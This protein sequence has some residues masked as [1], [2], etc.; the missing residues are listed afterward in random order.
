MVE[1]KEV[2]TEGLGA[3]FFFFTL[4]GGL[5]GTKSTASSFVNVTSDMFG[6]ALFYT[7]LLWILTPISGAH[8]N[9]L[10]TL[11]YCFEKK[12]SWMD[13]LWYMLSQA[14][15]VL[16]ATLLILLDRGYL[17]SKDKY[18][19]SS[20]PGIAGSVNRW[21]NGVVGTDTDYISGILLEFLATFIFLFF[22]SAF[23]FGNEE[24][25]ALNA[26]GT[27][28]ALSFSMSTTAKYTGAALNPFH[29]IIPLLFHLNWR[30]API[31]LIGTP[32]GGIAGY[33][34][35]KIVSAIK[36]GDLNKPLNS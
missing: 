17:V 8:I 28:T 20:V 3:F 25:K 5:A 1:T 19:Y 30:A 15:G 11:G 32:L 7:F 36:K 29:Y 34:I 13:G 27:G 26:F 6:I 31:Y 22:Y 14:V 33:W 16:I 4:M 35:W 10:I 23:H 24:P 2:I 21:N 18:W 12:K 9:P